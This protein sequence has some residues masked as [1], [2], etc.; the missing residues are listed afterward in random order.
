MLFVFSMVV[1]LSACGGKKEDKG[2]NENSIQGYWVLNEGKSKRYSTSFMAMRFN[3][4]KFSYVTVSQKTK[5]DC[6]I[7]YE[8]QGAKIVLKNPS[9]CSVSNSEFEVSK[10]DDKELVISLGADAYITHDKADSLQQAW[11]LINQR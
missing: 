11:T 8:V 6:E 7:D 1:L 3:A 10:V 9:K 5:F 4:G 2:L